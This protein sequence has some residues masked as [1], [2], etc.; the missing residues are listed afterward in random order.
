MLNIKING[1]FP[2]PL[3]KSHS[4]DPLHKQV[5]IKP[6]P[7]STRDRSAKDTTEEVLTLQALRVQS[8]TPVLQG[9]AVDQ[10]RK[11]QFDG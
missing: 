1:V 9:A 2:Y 10:F 6:K 11:Y 8:M 5:L 4:S 3:L 7:V